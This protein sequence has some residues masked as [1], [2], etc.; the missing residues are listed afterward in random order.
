MALGS[1]R[2]GSVRLAELVHT[3]SAVEG[4]PLVCEILTRRVILVQVRINRAVPLESMKRA[5][6]PPGRAR[7][8]HDPGATVAVVKSPPDPIAAAAAG[9]AVGAAGA[10]CPGT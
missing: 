8:T 5:S 1:N 9:G 6:L 7:Y 2:A 3:E 10:D 4:V